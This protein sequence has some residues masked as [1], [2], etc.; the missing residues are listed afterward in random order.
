[1]RYGHDHNQQL[2]EYYT[3]KSNESSALIEQELREIESIY[4]QL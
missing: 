2:L 3:L 1:M 4:K